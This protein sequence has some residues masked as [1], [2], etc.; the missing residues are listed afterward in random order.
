MS[1][2]QKFD[3]YYDSKMPNDGWFQYC[4]VCDIIT[5]K[6]HF[7]KNVTFGTTIKVNVDI[8]SYLCSTCKKKLNNKDIY[9]FYETNC[10]ELITN[11]KVKDL[12]NQ[13]HQTP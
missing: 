8:Y 13:N 3:I 12:L 1:T 9:K 6:L 11:I 7:Y 10:E 2:P 4:I 5:S